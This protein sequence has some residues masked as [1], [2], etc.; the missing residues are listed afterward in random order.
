[1]DTCQGIIERLTFHNEEN[2]YTVAKLEKGIT[3]VGILPGV[4]V[5]ETVKLSGYWVTHPE[6]GRQFKIEEFTTVYPGTITGITRY[7]GSGLIKGIGPV[8]ADRIVKVFGEQTLHIIEND[9]QRL[10]E[11]EGVGKK[12]TDM[13][14]KAW[15]EQ[16][17]IKNV[18]L[19][20]QSHSISTTYAVKIQK[21][22]GDKSLR[23]VKENPYQLTYDIWGI[24]FKTAD[25]IGRNIGFEDDN[26]VRIKAGILYVLNEAAN[27]GHVYLPLPELIKQCQKILNVEL[28]QSDPIFEELVSSQL[29]IRKG[30]KI[31][32]PAFYYAE[33][34]ITSRVNNLV[35][36]QEIPL[37]PGIR[38]LTMQHNYF[39]D[40][41]L[42]AIRNALKHKI[43]ILTGGPGTGKTTT[44]KGIIDVHR[45]LK[46]RIMLTAPTGRAAKRMTD[47]IGLE[48][49]TIHRLLNF[50]P[51]A[52]TFAYNADNPLP[53][54]LLVVDEV[55]MIDTVLMNNLLKAVKDTTTLILVGDVDQIPSVG[56]GN[57]LS[58]MI[59][60]K[61]IPVI[62]LSK[63]F[64]QAQTSQIIM[65]AH[66][67][68]QGRSP[69]I[70]NRGNSDLFFLEE[71]NNDKIPNLTLE[72]CRNRLPARYGFDPIKDIQVLA[73]MYKGKTGVSSLNKFLQEGLNHSEIIYSRVGNQYRIGDKVMQ[74]RNNYG[75]Q[76]FNGDLGYVAGIDLENQYLQIEMNDSSVKYDFAELDEITLAYAVTV[77]KSQGSEYPCV[78]LPL[79]TSH[80]LMLQRNLLYTAITRATKLMIIIGTKKALAIAVRNNKVKK[81]Y[82]SLTFK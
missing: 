7:L 61:V 2:S 70:T 24:G 9:I 62:R 47:V 82:T 75:K 23:I 1:M 53:T 31:Y 80:Y 29:I 36:Q 57:V 12:R 51:Q 6:Y 77:H 19:F 76:V 14:A 74:L 50:R 55:S 69:N 17:A 15:V 71:E 27:E 34:G 81:R 44:I 13:I 16:K 28:D 49:K 58:D 4:S 25:T 65:N 37:D 21:T 46:K 67:I 68:N 26:P 42:E 59:E 79:T 32:L 64:R 63:I 3:V 5:G 43:L 40:E 35:H 33:H 48:A 73:P 60:S 41:Q 52:N 56:P 10:I 20:L 11:V 39:S 45:Q 78:V 72:L 22:Y 30:D 54:E 66:R 8:T 18:M 38:S